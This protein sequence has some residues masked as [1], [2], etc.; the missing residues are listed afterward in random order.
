VLRLQSIS[1]YSAYTC[2]FARNIHLLCRRERDADDVGGYIHSNDERWTSERGGGGYT[3]SSRK[4]S[5]TISRS[6]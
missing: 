1:K 4:C 5:Y 3:G 6:S 2:L